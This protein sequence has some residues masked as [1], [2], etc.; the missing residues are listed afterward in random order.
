[1]EQFNTHWRR[2]IHSRWHAPPDL[3]S[4]HFGKGVKR[5]RARLS[6]RLLTF[7]Q[8]FEVAPSGLAVMPTFKSLKSLKPSKVGEKLK[9]TAK[10]FKSKS[11]TDAPAV[12]A[13]EPPLQAFEAEK[14][15]QQSVAAEAAKRVDEEAAAAAAAAAAEME[16]AAA[17]KKSA[18]EKAAA[19]QAAAEQEKAAAKSKALEMINAARR[20]D[21]S[22]FEIPEAGCD[23]PSDAAAASALSSLRAFLPT[24][25]VS[26]ET[27]EEVEP[28]PVASAEPPAKPEAQAE[29]EPAEQGPAGEEPAGEEED[30]P[31]VF[32]VRL[33]RSG[34]SFTPEPAAPEPAAEEA[35]VSK[36]KPK[37][38]RPSAEKEEKPEAKRGRRATRGGA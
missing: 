32:G 7:K 20:G 8:P 12:D 26:F 5:K 1:M 22:R 15:I 10:S 28:E 18:D 2:A 11:K 13:V 30:G 33:R 3:S 9:A 24:R 34:G 17:A 4:S 23:S 25:Q 16:A 36:E 27:K 31:S 38:G 21:S 19:E 37:R 6:S 14:W 29:Q 35:P